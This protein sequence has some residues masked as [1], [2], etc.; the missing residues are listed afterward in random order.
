MEIMI[1][2]ATKRKEERGL[3]EFLIHQLI[4]LSCLTTKSP[5]SP[6]SLLCPTLSAALTVGILVKR[7]ACSGDANRGSQLEKRNSIKTKG[8]HQSPLFVKPPFL[9]SHPSPKMYSCPRLLLVSSPITVPSSSL[10]PSHNNLLINSSLPFLLYR[11]FSPSCS[12]WPSPSSKSP[13][14]PCS[15]R[16]LGRWWWILLAPCQPQEQNCSTSCQTPFPPSLKSAACCHEKLTSRPASVHANDPIHTPIKIYFGLCFHRVL[17]RAQNSKKC[18][19][20]HCQSSPFHLHPDPF[21]STAYITSFLKLLDLLPTTFILT[22]ISSMF[23]PRIILWWLSAL[24]TTSSQQ[25]KMPAYHS[26]SSPQIAPFW[27]AAS[28]PALLP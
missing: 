14:L 6:P 26:L 23:F 15:A 1:S 24:G 9:N 28:I 18:D 5:A 8:S 20:V 12:P 17:C 3:P 22:L 11:E 7:A 21:P 25:F 16:G 19:R 27:R 4:R 13:P 10:E 2:W